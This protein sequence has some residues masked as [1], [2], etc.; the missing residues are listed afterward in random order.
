LPQG[1]YDR[2]LTDEE[3]SN[4]AMN[5]D[6]MDN[7]GIYENFDERN[8][9]GETYDIRAGDLIITGEPDG[10]RNYISLRDQKEIAIEPFRSATVI[11]F[12]KLKLPLDM[13]GELWIRNALQHRGL[14]FTGGDIDPGFW[15]YL[16][17]K[18]HNLGP[19]PISI[20]YQKEIA[21]IRF[22]RMHRPAKRSY[23]TT[24]IIRPRDDQL[25]PS[26][27]R[28]VYDWLQ[29]SIKLDDFSVDLG[30]IKSIHNILLGSLVIGLVVGV[31]LLVIQKFL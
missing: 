20:G 22:V 8:V 31:F 13:Y 19:V 21:S 30:H 27:P 5:K 26:P 14:A 10:K 17:I 4:W 18:I 11:S 29:M 6:W 2:T 12:E 15:G 3:I 24:E 9:N 23:A 1:T 25:P 28:I 16:Y 7:G